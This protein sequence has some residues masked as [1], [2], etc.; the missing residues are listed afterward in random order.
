M[1]A[2]SNITVQLLYTQA[3]YLISRLAVI[4]NNFISNFDKKQS[5]ASQLGFFV[6]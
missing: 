1:K 3:V 6:L 4:D 2:L 5:L